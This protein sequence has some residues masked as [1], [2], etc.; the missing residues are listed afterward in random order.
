MVGVMCLIHRSSQLAA[1]PGDALSYASPPV[2]I[3]TAVP[4]PSEATDSSNSQAGMLWLTFGG[5]LVATNH[6]FVF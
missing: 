4:E 3:P 1:V 6:L 5:I 2:E